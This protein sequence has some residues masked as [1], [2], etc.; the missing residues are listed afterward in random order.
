[1]ALKIHKETMLLKQQF[2]RQIVGDH[3]DEVL[4]VLPM[5]VAFANSLCS[6]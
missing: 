3:Y 5:E 1:M 6:Y 4:G 2:S